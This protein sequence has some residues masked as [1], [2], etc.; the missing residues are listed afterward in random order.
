MATPGTQVIEY[1]AAAEY[2]SNHPIAR[3]IQEAFAAS[4]RQLDIPQISRH[5]EMTGE[6]VQA[7]YHGSTIIAGNDHLLHREKI[8]HD[9]CDFDTTVVHIAVDGDYAGHLMIGDEVKPTAEQA[10]NALRGEGIGQI[11]MLT[12]DN[13]CRRRIGG[14]SVEAGSILFRSVAG[15]KGD[16]V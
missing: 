15:G 16:G 14:Q 3:S 6:G 10:I 1:A 7:L 12:G 8:S 13:R 2:H 9:K 11:V 4:G 5:L